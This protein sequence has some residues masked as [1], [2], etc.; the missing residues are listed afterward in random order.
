MKD[1]QAVTRPA[2]VPVSLFSLA[3]NLF[4]FT[5]V[6]LG[7]EKLYKKYTGREKE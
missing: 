2:S 3:V 1:M 4:Y 7:W 6:L 5:G